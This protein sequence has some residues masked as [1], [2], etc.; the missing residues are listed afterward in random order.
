MKILVVTP[1]SKM[2]GITTATVN[3]CNELSKRGN[4]V[5]LLDLSLEYLCK[6]KLNHAV[7]IGN[8]SGWSLYWNLGKSSIKNSKFFKKMCFG[9]LGGFKKIT[10]KSG[11]WYKVI[12]KKYEQFADF[13]VA[14][15]FRQCAVCY[16]FVLNK[17]QAK[18][19][20]AFVHG[21]LSYM[22]NISSWKK[23]MPKFD[24]VAYVSNSVRK[25]FV[26]KYAKLKNNACTIYNMFDVEKIKSLAMEANALVFDKSIKNIVTVAR[27]DNAFKRIDWIPKICA[28]IVRK[29]KQPFHWYIVGDGPD[30]DEVKSLISAY[31]VKDYI[32]M[33]GATSNPYAIF[34]DADFSVLLSKSEAYPMTV[35]ESFILGVPIIVSRFASIEEMMQNGKHGLI[36]ESSMES[37]LEAILQFLTEEEALERC[38]GFLMNIEYT[39]DKEYKQF[40]EAVGGKECFQ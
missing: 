11:F 25:E 37:L 8:L 2:G 3:F 4:D 39:N 27:V 6:D 30:F 9:V 7:R 20:I 36:A 33:V 24:K 15:A 26:T 29:T 40:I 35:I 28:E 10:I 38:K 22:G 5:Y 31:G 19:K 23:Y 12:F 34:K 16:Y 18:K 14:V 32:T 21:E 13:D 17:V 1:D